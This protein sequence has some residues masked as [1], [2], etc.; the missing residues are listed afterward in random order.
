MVICTVALECELT[1][2]ISTWLLTGVPPE[3]CILIGNRWVG[4]DVGDS[5]VLDSCIR[6]HIE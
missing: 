4:A 2:R 5:T 1:F 6:M 3:M